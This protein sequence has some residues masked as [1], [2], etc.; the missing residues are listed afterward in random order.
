M[1]KQTNPATAGKK[2][3]LNKKTVS[4]LAAPA[5]NSKNVLELGP[6][7]KCFTHHRCWGF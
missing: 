5:T 4:N 1:K 6:T 7:K 3:R 2:L